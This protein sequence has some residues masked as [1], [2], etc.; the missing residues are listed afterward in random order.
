MF[1]NLETKESWE[2]EEP[3]KSMRKPLDLYLVVANEKEGI[4]KK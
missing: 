4:N 3:I 2:V 1:K